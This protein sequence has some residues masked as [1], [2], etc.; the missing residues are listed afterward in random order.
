MRSIGNISLKTQLSCL[1]AFSILSFSALILIFLS[2]LQDTQ[3]HINSR[4]EADFD[5]SITSSQATS[6]VWQVRVD[7]FRS[8]YSKSDRLRYLSKLDD[9][10]QKVNNTLTQSFKK[11]PRSKSCEWCSLAS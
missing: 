7:Y 3:S 5:Y 6:N 8:V 2:Y 4:I 11:I 10:Y 9:W 1:A